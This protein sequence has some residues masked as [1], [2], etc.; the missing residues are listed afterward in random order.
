[1]P[2]GDA[3]HANDQLAPMYIVLF[4]LQVPRQAPPVRANCPAWPS[5]SDEQIVKQ[6]GRRE[7]VVAYQDVPP[8]VKWLQEICAHCIPKTL[9]ALPGPLPKKYIH[10]INISAL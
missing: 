2:F 10:I 6:S 8:V 9:W 5:P 4:L 1:M 3:V 7:K